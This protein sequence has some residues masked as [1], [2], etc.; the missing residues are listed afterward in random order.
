MTLAGCP[1][2]AEPEA[3]GRRPGCE[4]ATLI[5]SEDEEDEEEEEEEQ[6]GQ[7]HTDGKIWWEKDEMEE[8]LEVDCLDCTSGRDAEKHNGRA[9]AKSCTEGDSRKSVTIDLT[10]AVA[11]PLL[12]SQR[13][14]I[15]D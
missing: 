10:R 7:V 3:L 11:V 8:E 13:L 5:V 2:A 6:R 15:K 4:A 12:H 14:E 9:S 1:C